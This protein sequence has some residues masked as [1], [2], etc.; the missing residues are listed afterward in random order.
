MSEIKKIVVVTLPHNEA[1]AK[2]AEQN[3]NVAQRQLPTS[4]KSWEEQPLHVQLEYRMHAHAMFLA[5][6]RNY[7]PTFPDHEW[8]AHEEMCYHEDMGY[9]TDFATA[10]MNNNQ[11]VKNIVD[12]LSA[13]VDVLRLP[14]IRNGTVTMVDLAGNVGTPSFRDIDIDVAAS[15]PSFKSKPC[16]P[17]RFITG[18]AASS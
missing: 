13:K 7:L 6:G 4:K 8:Y 5:T 1:I 10:V 9:A 14:Q 3:W 16:P 15:Y 12:E 11:R 2:A 17:A 18:P